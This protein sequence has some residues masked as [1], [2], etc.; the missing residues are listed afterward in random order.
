MDEPDF[1]LGETW[2]LIGKATDWEGKPM[3]LVAATIDV[4]VF[5]SV[6]PLL[7]LDLSDGVEV[8]NALQGDYV[9]TITPEHQSG[10][11]P[12]VTVYG[13][14]IKIVLANGTTSVQVNRHI[15]VDASAFVRWA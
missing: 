8:T 2:F 14:Q 13:L 7:D 1:Y 11:D 4:R 5:T 9:V 10:W 3:S 12:R 15:R 6:G